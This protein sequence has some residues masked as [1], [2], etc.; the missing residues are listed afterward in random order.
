MFDNK[1]LNKK[2]TLFAWFFYD[3]TSSCVAINRSRFLHLIYLQ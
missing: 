1:T 3:I 2:T